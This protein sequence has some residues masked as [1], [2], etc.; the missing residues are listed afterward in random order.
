M[1]LYGMDIFISRTRVCFTSG[2]IF[3]PDDLKLAETM[4]NRF[5]CIHTQNVCC[6]VI[7]QAVPFTGSRKT[8]RK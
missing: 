8:L 2:E 1:V 4:L 5:H 7:K 6:V 3:G